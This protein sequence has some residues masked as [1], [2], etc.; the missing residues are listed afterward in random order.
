MT[1]RKHFLLLTPAD[2]CLI[3]TKSLIF[4]C[5]KFR[6]INLV[7]QTQTFS[8]LVE[9]GAKPGKKRDEEQD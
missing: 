5:L 4:K 3:E 6:E 9:S 1:T 7:P 8:P 2:R